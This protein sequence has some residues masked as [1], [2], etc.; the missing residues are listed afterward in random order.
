MDDRVWPAEHARVERQ[1]VVPPE[2]LLE[3]HVWSAIPSHPR[4]GRRS[5]RSALRAA[6][7]PILRHR[8]SLGRDALTVGG[9]AWFIR[10][11]YPSQ[12]M[13]YALPYGDTRES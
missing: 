12:L 7:P 9:E 1:R 6:V 4:P 13:L 11:D 5:Y 3:R 2:G 10:G 8:M